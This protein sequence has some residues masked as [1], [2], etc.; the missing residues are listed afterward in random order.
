MGA[1]RATI[2]KTLYARLS[3]KRAYHSRAVPQALPTQRLAHLRNEGNEE[4]EEEEE[5]AAAEEEEAGEEEEE[6]EESL[7]SRT[8]GV[9][10][11][12]PC[13]RIDLQSI[14]MA[15]IRA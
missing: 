13:Q 14:S 4:E 1:L 9:S 15:S 6:E 3:T 10:V 5:E 12:Q 7:F 2:L 8:R 11:G